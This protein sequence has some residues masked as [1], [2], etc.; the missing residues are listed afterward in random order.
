MSA[1]S[2]LPIHLRRSSWMAGCVT[3]RKHRRARSGCAIFEAQPFGD[4]LLQRRHPGALEELAGRMASLAQEWG[5]RFPSEAHQVGAGWMP[6]EF[7]GHRDGGV[8]FWYGS[9]QRIDGPGGPR[10]L[11]FHVMGAWD[12]RSWTIHRVRGTTR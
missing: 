4:A 5:P 12:G 8:R 6:C 9:A 3:T 10:F 11:H 1:E 7:K 2:S